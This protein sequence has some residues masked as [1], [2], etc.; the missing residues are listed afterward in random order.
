MKKITF[1]LASFIMVILAS[2]S[3]EENIDESTSDEILKPI[4][5]DDAFLIPSG[6]QIVKDSLQFTMRLKD[7]D[8]EIDFNEIHSIS[9]F[10]KDPI[11]NEMKPLSYIDLERDYRISYEGG[12]DLEELDYTIYIENA[13]G[14][15]YFSS[16]F[17]LKNLT[18]IGLNISKIRD[19]PTGT[20]DYRDFDQL[21]DYFNLHD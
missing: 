15:D 17:E 19:I 18:I 5:N 13:D 10:F 1:F 12:S 21:V 2:C 11:L 8:L 3:K 16:S 9:L 14:T 4:S 7:F 6:T 20:L